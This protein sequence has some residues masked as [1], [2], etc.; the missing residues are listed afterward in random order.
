LL[1]CPRVGSNVLLNPPNVMDIRAGLERTFQFKGLLFFF[2]IILGVTK[3]L[4]LKYWKW[5]GNIQVNIGSKVQRGLLWWVQEHGNQK[6]G[7]WK[8]GRVY[9]ASELASA[10]WEPLRQWQQPGRSVLLLHGKMAVYLTF[11]CYLGLWLLIFSHKH[12]ST[13]EFAQSGRTHWRNHKILVIFSFT[14]N[15]NDLKE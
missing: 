6:L 8:A 7:E 15:Q 11:P 1:E 10:D 3:E 2:F 13:C 14:L 9:I 4:L 12:K 5:L